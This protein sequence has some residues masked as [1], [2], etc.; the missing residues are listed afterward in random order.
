MNDPF[1]SEFRDFSGGSAKAGNTG[2]IDKLRLRLRSGA[3]TRVRIDSGRGRWPEFTKAANPADVCHALLPGGKG[4]MGAAVLGVDCA[5][6]IIFGL[7][8]RR[9]PGRTD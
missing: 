1:W 3:T 8:V 4:T 7:G 2:E 6:W 5:P 9:D